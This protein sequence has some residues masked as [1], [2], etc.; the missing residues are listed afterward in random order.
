MK[1]HLK[2]ISYS[3]SGA[4]YKRPSRWYERKIEAD[5]KEEEEEIDPLEEV[6]LDPRKEKEDLMFPRKDL[7]W[8]SMCI[9]LAQLEMQVTML[10]LPISGST[11]LKESMSMLVI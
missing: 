6:D 1:S 3:D 9:T 4:G 8:Q 5:L 2:R 7:L 10:Q 11:A